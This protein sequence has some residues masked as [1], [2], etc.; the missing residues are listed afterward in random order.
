M[1]YD[2]QLF[3]FT[4]E[5]ERNWQKIR[6]EYLQLDPRI[7]NFHR[8][9]P[10]E[11]YVEKLSQDNGWMN[12]WQV[13][14]DRPKNDWKIYALSYQG[15]FPAEAPAKFPF[16]ASLLSRLSG[17]RVCVFSNLKALAHIAPHSHP[18][19][20]DDLLIYHLGIDVVPGKSYLWVNHQF[21]EQRNGKSIIFDGA[22]EHFAINMSDTDRVVLYLEFDR[23]RVQL[24]S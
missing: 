12:S 8:V 10:Y 24:K 17:F 9:A 19:M 14:S 6:A 4:Q 22:D 21:E 11:T 20:E 13:D 18:E 16:I 5:F 1:F 7:L 2:P 15:I 23:H 3:D